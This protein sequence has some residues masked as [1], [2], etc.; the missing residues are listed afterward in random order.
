M[1]SLLPRTAAALV[2]LAVGA[3]ALDA[4]AQEPPAPPPDPPAAVAAPPKEPA[5]LQV[6]VAPPSSA[7]TRSEPTPIPRPSDDVAIGVLVAA[8]VDFGVADVSFGVYDALKA[9]HGELPARGVGIAEAVVAA[10]QVIA[11]GALHG[12]LAIEAND[13]DVDSAVT[14]LLPGVANTLFGHGLAGAALSTARPDVLY[15]VPWAVG[16]DTAF[17]VSAL[18]AAGGH[19]LFSRPLGAVEMALTAPQIAVASYAIVKDPHGVLGW[20][21][22][23]GWSGALFVHGLVSVIVPRPE[24]PP[25]PETPPAAP[26]EPPVPP[27]P[28]L[29]VPGSIEVGPAPIAGGGGV[30]VRGA[31]W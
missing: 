1:S 27:R 28:P 7:P 3:G 11:F 26:A 29:L 14:V 15:G 23:V 18:A 20:A 8:L 12:M 22:L 4:A 16:F 9:G 24:P 17:T 2:A 21:P 5:P 30:S 25:P 19:H 10:P 6:A 31:F 13:R